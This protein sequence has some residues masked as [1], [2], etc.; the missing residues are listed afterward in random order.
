[1]K[2]TSEKSPFRREVDYAKMQI[3]KLNKTMEKIEQ[4]LE[5]ND[6]DGVYIEAFNFA[7][8]S[9]NLTLAARQLPAYT[10]NPQARKMCEKNIID[11]FPVKMG[12]TPEG[13]FGV[14]IPAL[15]PKKS[16]G[17]NH[18]IFGSLYPAMQNFFNGQPLPRK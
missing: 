13:W 3:Q 5:V 8:V 16:K 2:N 12:F 4:R 10:G 6:I 1:M 15:L 7:A 14:V 9:E 11:N 17:S 18:Y